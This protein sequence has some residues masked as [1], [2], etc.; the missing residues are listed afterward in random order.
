METDVGQSARASMARW[1]AVA[2]HRIPEMWQRTDPPR[3]PVLFVNPRSGGGKATRAGVAERARELGIDVI[4]LTDGGDLGELVAEAVAGGA[5]VL[6]MAGGD[7]SLATVASAACAHGLTFICIPAGTRNHFAMDVGIDRRD[8]TGAVDAFVAGVERRIDVG[9]LNGR[10]FL[11]NVCLGVYGEAVRRPGY[12]R[13]KIR[14]LVETVATALGA[15]GEIPEVTLVDDAGIEH[16]QPAIV[17]VSNNPYVLDPGTAPGTR[18]T[19]DGGSLG[20]VVVAARPDV[21]E[22]LART[23]SAPTFEIDAAGPLHAGIDG[24]AVT[25]TPPLAFSIRPAALRLRIFAG[26]PGATRTLRHEDPR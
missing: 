7:G 4:V 5:D 16:N 12:R 3:K 25:V 21:L 20:I 11:N 9:E 1:G 2:N 23:W 10:I 13:A 15:A 26:H 17:L 22:P 18:A 14:T 24:E 6:G 19:L 8:L